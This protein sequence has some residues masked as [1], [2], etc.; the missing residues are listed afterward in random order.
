MADSRSRSR[1]ARKSPQRR[2]S[3]AAQN[4]EVG[5]EGGRGIRDPLIWVEAAAVMLLVARVLVPTEG[6]VQGD[7]LWITLLWFPVAA[8]WMLFRHSSSSFSPTTSPPPRETS[9]GRWTFRPGRV[10]E[11][12]VVLLVTG[13]LLATAGV[14]LH[15]GDRRAAVN[16]LWEWVALATAWY[17]LRSLLAGSTFR[18]QLLRVMLA[19]VV[20][21]STYGLWQHFVWYPQ[22]AVQYTSLRT[23]LDELLQNPAPTAAELRRRQ[24]LQNRLTERQIPLDGPARALWENRL[25][26]STEPFG[27][28]ALANTFGGFLAGWLFLLATT[29]LVPQMLAG[30]LGSSPASSDAAAAGAGSFRHTL[31]PAGM[32]LL[33][34]ACLL[35]TKS[36]TAWVGTAAGTLFVVLALIRGLAM[37][38]KQ[39]QLSD[40][41][42]GA[43]ASTAAAP[44]VS[45]LPPAGTVGRSRWQRLAGGAIVFFAVIAP[46]A[47]SRLDSQVVS[48]AFLSLRYRLQYWQG[49]LGVIRESPWLGVGPGNFR[50]HYLAYKLPES[51]EEIADPHNLLL[52]IW[53][54]GGLTAVAG[55]CLVLLAAGGLCLRVLRSGPGR[56]ESTPTDAGNAEAAHWPA[57]PAGH[58]RQD[59]Q[60]G[61]HI[62][63]PNAAI[64]GGSCSF[65][66]ILLFR[67]LFQGGTEPA[68]WCLF[69]AWAVFVALLGNSSNH[70]DLL[71]VGSLGGAIALMVHLCGAGGIEMPAVVQSLLLLLLV[72]S[73]TAASAEST[74]TATAVPAGTSVKREATAIGRAN[75]GR[76]PAAAGAMLCLVLAACCWASATGPEWQRRIETQLGDAELM[77]T[78]RVQVAELHY[79]RAAVL[80]PLSPDP[81]ARLAEVAFRRWAMDTEAAPARFEDAVRLQKLA[82]RQEP[83]GPAGWRR[84]GDFY[85][86]RARRTK[87]TEHAEL[88]AAAYAS[89]VER[90]PAYAALRASFA[91]AL[92]LAGHSDEAARQ[93]REALRL[94]D[95]NRREGHRDKLLK[96]AQRRELQRFPPPDHHNATRAGFSP[97]HA[98]SSTVPQPSRDRR[99][100]R[101]VAFR[102]VRAAG[103]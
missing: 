25:T 56:P 40:S 42:S 47:L 85:L 7:S 80:D 51:S 26:A 73:T 69:A 27:T 48:Q 30:P 1:T 58:S 29:T 23:E 83:H 34:V 78:G 32:L 6:A 9:R 52:D 15:G 81:V 63:V 94:D 3:A 39:Q 49:A 66:L 55:L 57:V 2:R 99:G 5:F 21:T 22:T 43:P 20:A 16:L 62:A 13:H 60:G 36:R 4:G 17:V 68:E 12:G 84:L 103:S 100:R 61:R 72:A 79:R 90:Y 31:I 41:R 64:V 8:V 70:P 86:A 101:H 38:P 11:A 50:A 24:E 53:C 35:L 77:Q 87:Q 82:I 96:D 95:I 65:L 88:A 91:Q 37:R 33:V 18:R 28:F 71:S 19:L 92:Q 74:Q 67:E 75:G 102:P 46:L 54:S 10:L 93:A 98:V 45:P 14:F 89:A 44:D 97:S 76:L 59:R